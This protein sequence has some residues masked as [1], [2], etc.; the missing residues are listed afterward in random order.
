MFLFCSEAC[1]LAIN[2]KKL[3]LKVYRTVILPVILCESWEYDPG[4]WT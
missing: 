2:I 3:K 4:N 1:N